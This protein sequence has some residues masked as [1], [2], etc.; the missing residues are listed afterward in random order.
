M[1]I[2]KGAD[3]ATKDIGNRIIEP[4]EETSSKFNESNS[5][6]NRDRCNNLLVSTYSIKIYITQ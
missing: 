2:D 3:V 5:E 6:S 4:E 1:K